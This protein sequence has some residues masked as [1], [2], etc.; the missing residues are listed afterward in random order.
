MPAL[1]DDHIAADGTGIAITDE[2]GEVTWAGLGDRV[3]RW[4]DLLTRRGLG[5]GDRLA[6]VLGNR[7]ETVEV[8]LAAL[9]AGITVVPVNWHLTEPEIEHVLVDSGSRALVVEPAH[10]AVAGAAARGARDCAARLVLGEHDVDGFTAVEPLL[11]DASGDEPADQVCGSVMLYTSGTTGAPK[12]VVNGLFVVGASF[13]RVGR[14]IEY[15]RVLLHVPAGG[16]YLLDGPWY[17][18]S[19]LFFALLALLRGARLYLR[20]R[21]DPAATLRLI[22][23]EQITATHLVPTQFIRLLRVDPAV[24][25]GFSGASL[26]QVWHGGGPCPVEV[27]HR[28]IEWWGP[29]LLEYYGATEGGAVTLIDSADWL[30]RP[31]SVGRAVPPYEVVVLDDEDRPLPAGRRGRVFIRRR[32]GRTFHYHNAPEKTRAAHLGAALFTFGEVGHLDEAGFLFLSGRAQDLIVSGGVN[33]YPAEVEA[34]LLTHPAVRDVAVVGAPDDEFGERVVAVV[35]ADGPTTD[36]PTALDEHS[37]RSLAGFKVPRGYHFVAELPREANGKIRKDT[38]RG[39]V[40]T[41]A[42]AGSTPVAPTP[43]GSA[44]ATTAPAAAV[45]AAA[46]PAAPA[47]AV[48]VPAAPAS[49]ATAPAAPA[50]AAAAPAAAAPAGSA[51]EALAP[52]G[53]ASAAPAPATVTSPALAS[54]APASP[55][56]ASTAPVSATPAAS[57]VD[58]PDIAHPATFVA[59]V[60]HDEFARRRREEPV[61]WV[62]EPLLVR[63]S[64]MGRTAERGSGYW[65]V[66]GYDDVVSVSRRPTEFSSAAKGAFLVDPRTPAALRQTRQLLINMD[67]PQHVAIR[68]LVAPMFTPRAI[69]ELLDGIDAHARA[70]VDNV[71]RAREFDA[72]TDLAAE[73]PLLVLT[74]LL[75]V[76]RQDRHLLYR[77]SNHLVGFDDPE[78]GGGDVDVYRATFAEAFQYALDLAADRRENPTGDLVSLLANAETDGKRL[79]DREFCNF[80]LLLVVAGNETTRHLVSGSLEALARHPA[81]RA[82]L[83]SGEVGLDTAV[84]ELIRWITPIMQFRRTA[85]RDTELGGQRIAEGDKVVIYYTSANRDAAVFPDP[86]RLDLGREPNRHLAFGIGPHFCLGAHLAR[87]ELRALL[88]AALPHLGGFA[89]TGPPVRMASNFVNAVKSMPARIG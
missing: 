26:R 44:S 42:P 83:V 31:G 32:T 41:L 69:R 51:S 1:L 55:A 29:V 61:G 78:Y 5:R 34:V 14:L 46:V 13:D 49:A 79:S 60:P 21:F 67:D 43:N 89:L 35:E 17:H 18:S 9:H 25:S 16:R 77:W 39:D 3:N 12:G 56:P 7:R 38:L 48:P 8:L 52:D 30:R 53:S 65:A 70:L 63:H 76:P 6:C 2:T 75:G 19:Q 87:L 64:A 84:E 80:W 54:P 45:P 72:V 36:L 66:T 85:V 59:G 81:E 23:A 4:V 62:T 10:A 82:R 28:M 40:A 47:S 22:D 37:R 50:P 58:R 33:V 27:K 15:A 71:V 86:D 24:R 57:A 88:T 11:A 20:P 74:D 73:L 68:K